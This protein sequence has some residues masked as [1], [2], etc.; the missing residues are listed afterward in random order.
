MP[1]S[2]LIQSLLLSTVT[3]LSLGFSPALAAPAIV[4]DVNTGAVTSAEEADRRWSP[5]SLTKLM[6]AYVTFRSLNAGDIEMTSPVRMSSNAASEPPSKMGYA[7]GSVMTTDNALKMLIIKSAND[8]AV[9]LAE[10]VSGTEDAFVARMNAEARRLGMTSTNFVN[11]NGL[12]DAAQYTT[13][14]DLGILARAIRLEFPQYDAYFAAE[15]IQTGDTVTPTYNLLLGRYAGADGMKT[16]FVCASGFNLAASATRDGATLVAIVLGETSQKSRAEKSAG[17]LDDGFAK[18]K[19]GSAL[20][21]LDTLARDESQAALPAAD[22]SNDVCTDEARAN[23]WDGRQIEGFI[24]FSTASIGTLDR[25]P[26][27][28]QAGLGG[29]SGVSKAATVLNGVVIGAYPVPQPKPVRPTLL[30]SDDASK[31][32]LRPGFDVPVPVGRPEASSNG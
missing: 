32:G 19:T 1:M 31:F 16:G 11:A 30:D 15:G 3:A 10:A 8:V 17:L 2:R 9:A 23:R 6:T 24:T 25:P 20:P 22:I 21:R 27:A 12:H 4:V 28:L 26:R 7:V 13:A 29:A 5:A 14:R 18:L